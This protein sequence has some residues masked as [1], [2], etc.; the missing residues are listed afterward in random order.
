MTTAA[1]SNLVQNSHL[2]IHYKPPKTVAKLRAPSKAPVQVGVV[3]DFRGVGNKKLVMTK[4]F[5]NGMDGKYLATEDLTHVIENAT[6]ETLRRQNYQIVS[7]NARYIL[8]GNLLQMNLHWN[9]ELAENTLLGKAKVEFILTNV[10]TGT[11]VW[12]QEFMATLGHK[13]YVG[14]GASSAIE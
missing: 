13:S 1:C 6:R 5:G 4:V 2:E 14:I 12:R 8:T 10:E 3:N 11:P 7:N 9:D